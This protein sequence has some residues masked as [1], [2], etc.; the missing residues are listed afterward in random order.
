[1]AG[2]V[3]ATMAIFSCS[4]DTSGVGQSLTNV[5]DQL[6]ITTFEVEVDSTRT[7]IADSVFTLG[8]SSYLGRVRDPETQAD[9]KSEFTTQFH[10][11]D[12]LY[13]SPDDKF[14]S[15]ADDGK[16]AADS[17]EIVLYISSPYN[18]KD[19]L[20]AVK[21]KVYELQNT[22]EEGT[23]YYSSFDPLALGMVRTNGL[24]KSKMLTF[25][26]QLDT[27]DER[28]E[29]N[30]L[31]NIRITLN[32]PY[33][34]ADG[35]TYNNYGTYVIRQYQN[36]PEFFR[37]SYTFT[38][39][40]CPG[41]FFQITDG[42]GFYSK[43]T[44]IGITTY[45]RVMQ[46][47][48]VYNAHF[49]MAGTNEV[50]QTTYVTND[51]KAIEKLAAEKEHTYLKTPAGLFTEVALPIKKIKE[52]HEKDSLIAAKISFQRINN[53]SSDERMFGI[54]GTLLMVQKDSLKNFFESSKLPDNKLTYIAKYNYNGSTYKNN[55]TY[56]FIN[57]SN[58]ITSLWNARQKGVAEN[59]NW[60]VEHPDWNKVVLVPVNYD[61]ST[62]TSVD[63]DMSLTSVRLVGGTNNHNEPVK[64]SVVYGKFREK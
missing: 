21:M 18:A 41:M 2:V 36:H 9:V 44:N 13:I 38:H 35:T 54:P 17:C 16:A 25:L 5:T 55:N 32:G 39:N 49:T 53:Q 14:V 34:A 51:K 50:L 62:S 12:N 56:N 15:R 22:L 7:I 11:L 3:L 61:S 42:Y 31:N 33:T 46:A 64:V 37:N 29:S 59:P 52:G 23:R 24:S 48:T 57:I 26:N 6:D 10:M 63:H 58:L 20:S 27:D 47:D 28:S 19:S 40:V 1:M 8:N 45:Y 43:L 60:E 4:E 30:Y